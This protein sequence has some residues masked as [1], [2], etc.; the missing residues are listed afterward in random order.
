MDFD[1]VEFA[2]GLAISGNILFVACRHYGVQLIDVSV[3]SAPRHLSTVRT[4][5]AQSV[6]ARNGYLYT[7]VWATSEV[8]TVDVRDP[9]NP[10]I[11]AR[12]PLDGY[13]D[14]V[15]VEGDMLYVATGHHSRETPRKQQGDPGFGRGHGLELLDISDP[16]HPR[17]VSRVK[18]PPLYEIGNDM[19]GCDGFRWPCLRRRYLQRC[20]RR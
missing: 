14:G 9:W 18:F 19:W 13:G 3:P 7:G 6:V 12:T 2:T 16:A 5:E 4:G 15:D 11:T 1:T 17:W 8:V 20:F 10:V